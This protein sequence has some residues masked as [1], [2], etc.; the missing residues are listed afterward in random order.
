[1]YSLGGSRKKPMTAGNSLNENEWVSR[2]KWTS[3]TLSSARA[4]ATAR[5]GHGIWTKTTGP[6]RPRSARK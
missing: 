4:K 6:G 1:M 5:S 2:R 3:T